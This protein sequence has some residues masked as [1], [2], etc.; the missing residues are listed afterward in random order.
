MSLFD[1][2]RVNFMASAKILFKCLQKSLRGCNNLSP[3]TSFLRGE[4]DYKRDKK[5]SK[6][7]SQA[8]AVFSIRYPQWLCL[9]C[10]MSC[11]FS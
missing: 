6:A 1:K 5:V 10:A 8:H 2:L 7:N 3:S 11:L 9:G 4:F